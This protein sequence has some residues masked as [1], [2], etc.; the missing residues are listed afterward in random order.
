[1][2]YKILHG[3]AEPNYITPT[4]SITTEWNVQPPHKLAYYIYI[5]R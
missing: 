5:L 2:F 3:L 4:N 1:M